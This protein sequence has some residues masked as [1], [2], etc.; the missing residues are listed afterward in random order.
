MRTKSVWA[1]SSRASTDWSPNI[2]ACCKKASQRMHFS[3]RAE[4][5]PIG[6]EDPSP[7][8]QTSVQSAMLY[9]LLWQLHESRHGVTGQGSKDDSKDGGDS[10]SQTE[11]HHVHGKAAAKELHWLLSDTHR[12]QAPVGHSS[13]SGS[14]RTLIV[15]WTTCCPFKPPP[16]CDSS[17]RLGCF[18]TRINRLRDFPAN[19]SQTAPTHRCASSPCVC[20]CV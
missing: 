17:Q 9:N 1:P 18:R 15:R 7:L 4:T 19:R 3:Q 13:S 12:P 10:H 8:L 16:R 2:E 6:Q 11:H 14:C 20:V 5:V